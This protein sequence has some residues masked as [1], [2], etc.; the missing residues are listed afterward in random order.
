MNRML[1]KALSQRLEKLEIREEPAKFFGMI[2]VSKDAMEADTARELAALEE[3]LGRT[4]DPSTHELITVV[5]VSPKQMNEQFTE[6]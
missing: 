3:R 5:F 2:F 4:Y 1:S 6:K